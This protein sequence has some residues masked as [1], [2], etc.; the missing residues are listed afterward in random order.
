MGKQDRVNVRQNVSKGFS[1]NVSRDLSMANDFLDANSFDSSLIKGSEFSVVRASEG[2]HYNASGILKW[3]AANMPRFDHV[4]YTCEPRGLLNELSRTNIE[5]PSESADYSADW[6]ST[7]GVTMSNPGDTRGPDFGLDKVGLATCA[8]NSSVK[9]VSGPGT[10]TIVS[11][12]IYG[13]S[14]FVKP[15]SIAPTYFVMRPDLTAA[16]TFSGALYDLSVPEVVEAGVN[17]VASGVIR[18]K[19]D[20]FRIYNFWTANASVSATGMEL[21]ATEGGSYINDNPS[22][23]YETGGVRTWYFYGLQTEAI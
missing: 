21:I 3:A 19:N 2:S 8:E 11:G 4:P 5:F 17:S 14:L 12:T 10:A 22:T 23:S 1:I 7:V 9:T 16:A 18:L 20:W 13:T 6:V 15:G